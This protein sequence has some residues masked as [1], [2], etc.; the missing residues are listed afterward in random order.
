MDGWCLI[1][2]FVFTRDS[3]DCL[4]SESPLLCRYLNIIWIDLTMLLQTFVIWSELYCPSSF[5][6]CQGEVKI[7]KNKNWCVQYFDECRQSNM[8]KAP[9]TPV[10]KNNIWEDNTWKMFPSRIQFFLNYHEQ[11]QWFLITSDQLQD[12]MKKA[13]CTAKMRRFHFHVLI[14]FILWINRNWSVSFCWMAKDHERS[15]TYLKKKSTI[16]KM[17]I[18]Y[19]LSLAVWS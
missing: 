13:A 1:R 17:R 4:A 16:H 11:I 6:S 18:H 9:Y 15:K 5:C 3:S 10:Y 7:Y 12:I 8:S 19:L 2:L 14:S